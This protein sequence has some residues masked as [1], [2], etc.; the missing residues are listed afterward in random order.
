MMDM[1]LIVLLWLWARKAMM[2]HARSCIEPIITFTCHFAMPT[3]QQP[4]IALAL[5]FNSNQIERDAS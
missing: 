4:K 5:N 2:C 1:E 3:K